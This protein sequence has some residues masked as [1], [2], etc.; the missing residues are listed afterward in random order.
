MQYQFAE[1]FIVDSR[2]IT[3]KLGVHATPPIAP[4]PTPST[5]TAAPPPR[6]E[7]LPGTNRHAHARPATPEPAQ[8]RSAG[9]PSARADRREA[10]GGRWHLRS[11]GPPI[12]RSVNVS[13]PRSGLHTLNPH[14][15]PVA[16]ARG[17][18]KLDFCSGRC[19]IFVRGLEQSRQVGP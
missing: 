12:P 10:R 11:R 16:P 19:P 5:P 1:P 15:D 2:K 14:R 3:T 13:G 4:S 8:V 6:P 7:P 18:P 9:P 17:L